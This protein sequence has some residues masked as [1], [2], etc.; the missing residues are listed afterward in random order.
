MNQKLETILYNGDIVGCP[1]I[2][3]RPELVQG[4]IKNEK[5]SDIW[6]NEF[7]WFRDVNKLKNP[8]CENCENWDFC[9][10]DGTHTYNFDEHKPN[11]CVYKLLKEEKE[12]NEKNTSK[13]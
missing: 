6:K 13:T 2:E 8:E 9:K 12:K 3:R 11:L 7:K 10:G 5:F 1:D 4:N